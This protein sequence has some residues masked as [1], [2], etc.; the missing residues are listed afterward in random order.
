M[1]IIV[2]V[3]LPSCEKPSNALPKATS[4]DIGEVGLST[5]SRVRFQNHTYITIE[6]NSAN[7]MT[8]DPDCEC[9]E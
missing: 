2:G 9:K 4:V 3:L 6:R 5:I 8:H 1:F 7:A